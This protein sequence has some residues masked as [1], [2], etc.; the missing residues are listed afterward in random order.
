[1]G[2]NEEKTVCR[3]DLAQDLA[4]VCRGKITLPRVGLFVAAAYAPPA[5]TNLIEGDPVH[6]EAV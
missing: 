4:A 2:N 6:P 3:L 1:M 5:A